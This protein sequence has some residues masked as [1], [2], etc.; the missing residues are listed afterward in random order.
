MVSALHPHLGGLLPIPNLLRPACLPADEVLEV[1]IIRADL[2][3]LLPHLQ[4]RIHLDG[5]L[6]MARFGEILGGF[7]VLALVRIDFCQEQLVISAG[8]APFQLDLVQQFNVS[9]VTNADESLAGNLE[10]QSTEGLNGQGSPIVFCHTQARNL[11]RVQIILLL[12]VPVHA[13]GLRDIDG[14][15]G[16][17][18]QAED[19]GSLEADHKALQLLL[20]HREVAS[21][22]VKE[23][24][25]TEAQHIFV[26]SVPGDAVGIQF[27]EDELLI[28]EMV[29]QAIGVLVNHCQLHAAGAQVKAANGRIQ[30]DQLNGKRVVDED[31]E[32]SPVLEPHQQRLSLDGTS[33]DLDVPDHRLK[34]PLPLLQADKIVQLQFT[35]LAQHNVHGS[36]HQK[37]ALQFLHYALL[38]LVLEIV[39][40][41]VIQLVDHHTVRQLHR[42]P[43]FVYG[44][45]LDIILAPNAEFLLCHQLLNDDISHVIP[46]RILVLI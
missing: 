41:V 14:V 40:V 24:V 35:L 38:E 34:N 13:G 31:L 32:H 29:H 1:V 21:L 45:F 28:L 15:H 4:V 37:I 3:R 9:H 44:N 2:L 30:F 19:L 27:L 5:L 23:P 43:V 25:A 39:G 18:V 26:L 17:E 6:L 16:H 42:Q 20:V 46:I 10:I 7:L 12:K 8:Q 11:V 22:D 36:D 33:H